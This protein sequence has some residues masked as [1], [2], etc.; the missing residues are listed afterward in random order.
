MT[1][2]DQALRE[3]LRHAADQVTP[4]VLPPDL[5]GQVRH[6]R[7]R[8]SL[9][10]AAATATVTALIIALGFTGGHWLVWDRQ[11]PV[12]A[13]VTWTNSAEIVPKP[14]IPGRLGAGIAWTGREFV[15]WGGQNAVTLD[16][17]LPTQ[18]TDGAAYDPATRRW[19]KIAGAPIEGRTDPIV[20]WTGKEVLVWGGNGSGGDR[21]DGAAY[22]PGTGRWRSIASPSPDIRFSASGR[23][24]ASGSDLFVTARGGATS[25]AN[26]PDRQ[27]VLRTVL[28]YDAD[29]DAWSSFQASA[30]VLDLAVFRDGLLMLERTPDGLDRVERV[31]ADGR[32]RGYLDPPT[33]RHNTG[34]VLFEMTRRHA[35][36][37]V[38]GDVAIL[39]MDLS[40]ARA[41]NTSQEN[42]PGSSRLWSLG[43]DASPPRWRPLPAEA[44]GSKLLETALVRDT[45]FPVP[46][47]P[48]HFLAADLHE[49]SVIDA[50]TGAVISRA[51]TPSGWLTSR[52]GYS[53]PGFAHAD[54]LLFQ[55]GGITC[56]STGVRSEGL[57]WRASS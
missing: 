51:G 23:W 18:M 15:I 5:A 49:T 14:P 50:D 2:L 37:V 10:I 34:D 52:C 7:R 47:A 48:G 6:R 45:V 12:P 11:E 38:G 40:D 13:T 55:W 44:R 28:H 42:D 39:K 35:R 20:H 43:L 24:T 46:G 33:P 17:G 21:F 36:L 27:T 9:R 4:P 30:E 56:D 57:L 31:A 29:A 3:A 1:D 32:R 8:R 41:S 22:D 53:E 25:F 54:R 26:A 16:K 19:R